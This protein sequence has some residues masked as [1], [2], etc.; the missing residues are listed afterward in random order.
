MKRV[1]VREREREKAC[2][3]RIRRQTGRAEREN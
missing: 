3:V 2:G 1:G